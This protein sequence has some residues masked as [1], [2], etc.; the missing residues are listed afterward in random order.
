ML[1][2]FEKALAWAEPGVP[3]SMQLLP[4]AELQ[5]AQLKSARLTPFSGLIHA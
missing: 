3:E 2:L 1:C 4:L 5:G